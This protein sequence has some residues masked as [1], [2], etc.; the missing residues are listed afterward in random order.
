M[1]PAFH[2]GATDGDKFAGADLSRVAHHRHQ[3]A[4]VAGLDAQHAE[5]A[6]GAVEFDAL[7][8]ARQHFGGLLGLGAPRLPPFGCLPSAALGIG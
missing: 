1:L 5:A 6:L 2:P 8:R 3:L 4:V 7:N